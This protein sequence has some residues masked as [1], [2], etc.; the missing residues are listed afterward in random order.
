MSVVNESNR[1][2][3]LSNSHVKSLTKSHVVY[4]ASFKREALQ[5]YAEGYPSYEIWEE[6]GFTISDFES[7]YFRKALNRWK[8]QAEKAPNSFTR[9]QRGRKGGPRSFS[10]L[11]AEN[12]YLR[13]EN[14]FLKELQA[15]EK[16]LDQEDGLC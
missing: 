15:L 11:A 13:E 3:L 1:Q 5:K 14:A 9:E 12:A 8:R 2:R 16:E 10:S 4:Q 7:N 6:A